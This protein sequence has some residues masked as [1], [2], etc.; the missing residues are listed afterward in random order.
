MT[1]RRSDTAI[2]NFDRLYF[3]A[4]IGAAIPLSK[5]RFSAQQSPLRQRSRSRPGEASQDL[6]PSLWGKR[7]VLDAS[8]REPRPASRPDERCYRCHGERCQRYWI[9]VQGGEFLEAAGVGTRLSMRRHE[10]RG[11]ASPAGAL[12]GCAEHCEGELVSSHA[13]SSAWLTPRIAA[14][15]IQHGAHQIDTGLPGVLGLDETG[16]D[17][18]EAGTGVGQD[19]ISGSATPPSRTRARC[20]PRISS[21]ATSRRR[22]Q[23]PCG[24]PT[25]R[26]ARAGRALSTWPSS[27][28]CTPVAWSAGRRHA[29]CRP[30]W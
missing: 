1:P 19:D 20:G 18:D 30:T 29:R 6:L 15:D 16:I 23:M 9:A 27:S 21:T 3:A 4:A 13:G 24:S 26:I 14:C 10:L 5:V 7:V 22:D 28:T 17:V 12:L 11:N 25:S 8:R 2:L